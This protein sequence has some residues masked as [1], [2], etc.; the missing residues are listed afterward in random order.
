[1]DGLDV[2]HGTSQG[3]GLVD[4]VLQPLGLYYRGDPDAPIARPPILLLLVPLYAL[5]RKDRLTSFLLGLS[6]LHLVVWTQNIQS[7]RYL[8]PTFAFLGL[9][10]ANLLDLGMR[11]PRLRG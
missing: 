10:A 9:V 2:A 7:I 6:A 1:R 4:V 8:F 3:R 11:S 5:A